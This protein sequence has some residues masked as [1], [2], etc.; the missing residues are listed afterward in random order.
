[1][2]IFVPASLSAADAN[3]SLAQSLAVLIDPKERAKIAD[4]IKAHHALN[5]SEAKKASD[6][7]NLIK[8]H[9]DIL[10]ETNRVTAQNKKDAADLVKKQADFKAESEAE[11]VKI[12]EKW[13]DV[14]AA[15]ETAK[16]MHD[17]AEK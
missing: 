1:M 12:S 7:R 6:A 3:L 14:K 11:K 17:K 9:S 10:E 8:Q 2:D 15:A 16:N 4:D 13:S 5:E